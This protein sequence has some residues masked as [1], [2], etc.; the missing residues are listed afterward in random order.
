MEREATLQIDESELIRQALAGQTQAFTLLVDR[1]RDP[2]CGMAYSYIGSFDDAQDV[3]QEVLI[4]AY[5][6]LRDLREAGS[7]AAWLRRI[8]RSRCSDRLRRRDSAPLSLDQLAEQSGETGKDGAG[9]LQSASL[10]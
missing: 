4:Y 8:T 9:G 7:F 3:A 2:L 5:L 6:H 1:Y 10:C